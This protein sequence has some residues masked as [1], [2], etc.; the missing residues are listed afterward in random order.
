MAT[1][2]KTTPL[3]GSQ[4]QVLNIE[5]NQSNGSKIGRYGLISSSQAK[6]NHHANRSDGSKIGI[7]LANVSKNT[8]ENQSMN[9]NTGTKEDNQS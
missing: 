2:S 1:N 6:S 4:S 7:G 3:N 8:K 9:L 5:E